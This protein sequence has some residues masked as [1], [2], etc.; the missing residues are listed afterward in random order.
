M[1]VDRTDMDDMVCAGRRTLAL[2]RHGSPTVSNLD[3]GT[4]AMDTAEY[5]YLQL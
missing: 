3:I 4:N 2:V 1:L 5:L